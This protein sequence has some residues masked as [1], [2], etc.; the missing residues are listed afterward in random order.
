MKE[1]K[2]GSLSVGIGLGKGKEV[3]PLLSVLTRAIAGL[4]DNTGVE[5]CSSS[6]PS[7]YSQ[8]IAFTVILSVVQTPSDGSSTLWPKALS[9]EGTAAVS[10]CEPELSVGTHTITAEYNIDQF[11]AAFAPD[12]SELKSMSFSFNTGLNMGAMTGRF[13]PIVS[14]Q[15]RGTTRLSMRPLLSQGIFWASPSVAFADRAEKFGFASLSSSLT[16]R[17]NPAVVTGQATFGKPGLTRA[18]ATAGV[19]F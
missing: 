15:E 1:I 10:S 16:F 2:S 11:R 4:A 13:S 14:G 8:G 6:N 9:L 7:V 17:F 12:T 5:F 3:K 18:A 19:I